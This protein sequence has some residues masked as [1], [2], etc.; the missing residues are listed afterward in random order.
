[1]FI[2]TSR[3][4]SSIAGSSSNRNLITVIDVNIPTYIITI[5][6]V[7][8]SGGGVIIISLPFFILI[9]ILFLNF[10]FS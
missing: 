4:S 1:M 8:G 7:F 9:I 3:S 5:S 10:T 2:F 6:T